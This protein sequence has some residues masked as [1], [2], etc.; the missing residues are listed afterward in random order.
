MWSLLQ[1]ILVNVLSAAAV[2][3]ATLAGRQARKAWRN[4]RAAPQDV[5]SPVDTTSD[6]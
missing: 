5:T 2:T 1:G 4:R 3:A 6:D